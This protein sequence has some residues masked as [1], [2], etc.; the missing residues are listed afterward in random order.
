[1]FGGVRNEA[2]ED[3]QGHSDLEAQ[4]RRL[5]LL[6]RLLPALRH[7]RARQHGPEEVPLNSAYV[8]LI[9]LVACVMPFFS[10]FAGL[11]GAVT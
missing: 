3:I 10:A 4:R 8:L 2:S 11:V 6:A 9:T 1:V 7:A 5:P